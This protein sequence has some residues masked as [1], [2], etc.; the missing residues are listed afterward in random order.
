MR[1]HREGRDILLGTLVALIIVHFIIG[2]YSAVSHRN[3]Q[4]FTALNILFYAWLLYFFRDPNRIIPQHPQGILSPADGKVVLVKEVD[5]DEYLHERRI[6]IGVFMS[7]LNVHVNRSP[8]SGTVK[9]VKYHPGKYLVAWHPKSSTK[10]ER[11]TIVVENTQGVQVLF[12]QIA[13]FVARR[14]RFYPQEGDH[15]QQG[16]EYGFIKFGSR[17][18]IFLPLD[19]KIQ[20]KL[21]DKV[22]GGVSV[23]ATL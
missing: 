20:V 22:K 21:G 8:V 10:N 14:I 1:I 23:L 7:P 4:L 13:G 19:A 18:D 6:Q 11:T 5:E 2:R 15:I 12:R 16:N 9:Y 17:A 3:Y